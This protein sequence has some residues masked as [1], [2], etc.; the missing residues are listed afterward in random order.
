MPLD[1]ISVQDL[2]D[3]GPGPP[4]GYRYND[5]STIDIAGLNLAHSA[6]YRTLAA[7]PNV[8]FGVDE[9]SV[10][11]RPASGFWRFAGAPRSAGT[12]MTPTGVAV[13]QVRRV[14]L[15]HDLP[16][17]PQGNVTRCLLRDGVSC[18]LHR[19]GTWWLVA[20]QTTPVRSSPPG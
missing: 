17:E 19:D 8:A 12:A 15:D 2:I 13:A 9:P 11:A 20:G 6:K 3:H 1:E 5:D 14:A 16:V 7:N 10:S 18:A 4:V